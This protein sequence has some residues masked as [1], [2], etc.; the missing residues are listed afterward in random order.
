MMRDNNGLM[1]AQEL[2]AEE[3]HRKHMKEMMRM[4]AQEAKEKMAEQKDQKDGEHAAIRGVITDATGHAIE[5]MFDIDPAHLASIAGLR[6]E[7]PD[8]RAPGERPKWITSGHVNG[9]SGVPGG[10]FEKYNKKAMGDMGLGHVGKAISNSNPSGG[11]SASASSSAGF[12]QM[13]A[14]KN[15]VAVS[16]LTSPVVKKF[17]D[18]YTA[19]GGFLYAKNKPKGSKSAIDK[20]KRA[21]LHARIMAARKTGAPSKLDKAHPAKMPKINLKLN[22]L[23]KGNQDTEQLRRK[24]EKYA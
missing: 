9:A 6:E 2:Q 19:Q 14:G 3:Q 4:E 23:T 1:S 13:R 7:D 10:A 12:S 8:L 21:D 24:Q 15:D 11:G 18:L 20:A 16:F 22:A 5:S 17:G